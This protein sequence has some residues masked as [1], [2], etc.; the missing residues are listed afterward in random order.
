[1]GSLLKDV[2]GWYNTYRYKFHVGVVKLA[3]EF[4]II[5]GDKTTDYG[6]L[7]EFITEDVWRQLLQMHLK[8]TDQQKLRKNRII[9]VKI[10]AFVRQ[11]VKAILIA[12]KRGEDTRSIIKKCDNHTIDLNIPTKLGII[13]SLAVREL[14]EC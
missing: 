9:V 10:G 1:M 7:E 12:Q 13:G 5:Y 8:V 6:E 4:N 11:V 2:G 14:L 3:N